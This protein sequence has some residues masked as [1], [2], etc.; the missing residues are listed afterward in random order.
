MDI[1]IHRDGSW[2]PCASVALR[3]ET[4]SSRRGGVKL[5][6][7]AEH[8]DAAIVEQRRHRSNPWRALQQVT[9]P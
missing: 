2:R 5:S 6:Y 3:D 8:V 1:D 4:L 9:V 7:D